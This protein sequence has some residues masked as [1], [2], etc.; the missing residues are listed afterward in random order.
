M[1]TSKTAHGKVI[2]IGEHSAVYGY[3]ALVYPVLNA[4]VTISIQLSTNKKLI[5]PFYQGSFKN[6]PSFLSPYLNLVEALLKSLQLNEVQIQ[7]DGNLPIAAGMGFSAAVARAT[8]EAMYELA[9]IPLDH[10]TLKSWIHQGEIYAHGK[11]SGIDM[12]AI[13][14]EDPL[15]FENGQSKRTLRFNQGY[16]LITYSN[17]KGQTKDAVAYIQSLPQEVKTPHLEALGSLADQ[18]QNTHDKKIIGT[19]F[20]QAH[21]HLKSLGISNHTLDHMV[22]TAL[23]HGAL[24]AKLTGGGLGGCMISY[25]DDIKLLETLQHTFLT[26]GFH[27]QFVLNFEAFK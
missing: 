9:K 21:D 17:I 7:L 13:M 11:P 1:I 25:F 22:Q 18:L 23:N 26:Q 10:T 15:I 2:L 5:S 12:E 8:I 19:I 3:K 4:T 27:T 20:N 14:H 16:L 24:G 6:A